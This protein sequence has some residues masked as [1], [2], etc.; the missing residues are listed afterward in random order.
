[1]VNK[2]LEAALNYWKFK[3]DHPQNYSRNKK[4]APRPQ[5]IDYTRL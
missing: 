1:M 2:R 5:R 4:V 3:S